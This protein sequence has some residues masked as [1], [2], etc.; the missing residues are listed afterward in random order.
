MPDTTPAVRNLEHVV[1]AVT[2][3]ASAETDLT[4]APFAG[5][6]TKVDYVAA[7]AITGANTNSRTVA[8]VNKGAAGSGTTVVA[9]LA[10]VSGV[11]AVADAATAV[12]LSVVAGA[13]T[14]ASG[15]VLV[16]QSNAVGTGLAD[17][18]GLVHLDL[19]RG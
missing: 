3:A 12:T 16:W 15:D 1:P 6:I 19:T 2:I 7:T 4:E 5:T 8:L 9:S 18:G 14:I 13:T 11:N 17:P 10:L